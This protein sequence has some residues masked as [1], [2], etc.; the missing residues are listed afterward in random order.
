MNVVAPQP[1]LRSSRPTST[2]PHPASARAPVHPPFDHRNTLSSTAR[3]IVGVDREATETVVPLAR[4]NHLNKPASPALQARLG[5]KRTFRSLLRATVPPSI[6]EPTTSTSTGTDTGTD[7]GT[8]NVQ[9]A[10]NGSTRKL[11]RLD[12]K[13]KSPDEQ[14]HTELLHSIRNWTEEVREATEKE[15]N[16]AATNTSSRLRVLVEKWLEACQTS[17][18]DLHALLHAANPDCSVLQVMHHCGVDPAL[19]KYDVDNE[20]W[21]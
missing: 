21:L 16:Q 8:S 1:S 4:T 17:I 5:R 20:E 6:N 19:V 9:S 2:L 3:L 10:R 7:T 12:Q 13:D 14:S 11:R 15:K 18:D